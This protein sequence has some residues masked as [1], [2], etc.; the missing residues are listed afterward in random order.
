MRLVE[1]VVLQPITFRGQRLQPGQVFFAGSLGVHVRRWERTKRI[2]MTVLK[3][4]G[5]AQH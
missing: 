3:G 1:F 4:G 2:R 5:P